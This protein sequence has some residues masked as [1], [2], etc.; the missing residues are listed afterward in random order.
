MLYMMWKEIRFW[1]TAEKII[2]AFY[3][4]KS[5]YPWRKLPRFRGGEVS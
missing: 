5:S 4:R 1:P 2:L 3:L